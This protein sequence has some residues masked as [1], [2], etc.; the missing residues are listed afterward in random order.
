VAQDIALEASAQVQIGDD[1]RAHA[2]A[3]MAH[4]PARAGR[5]SRAVSRAGAAS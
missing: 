4:R 1:E 5:A 2:A 3:T